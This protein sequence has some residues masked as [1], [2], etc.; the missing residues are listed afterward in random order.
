MTNGKRHDLWVSLLL[1]GGLAAG[2][3]TQPPDPPRAGADTRSGDGAA[4]VAAIRTADRLVL[5]EG[6][7]HQ[8]FESKLLEAERR[9]KQTVILHDFPFYAEPLDLRG[10]DAALLKELLSDA[11]SFSVWGGEKFC[12]GFHP[13]YL[14]ECRVGK[15][16]Y[17]VLVCFGC[18][19]AKVFGPRGVGVRYDLQAEAHKQLDELLRKYH[20]N[21]PARS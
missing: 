14:V 2:C 13:D 6:L 15:D 11:D 20:K 19:E 4:A 7:P 18:H 10:E 5:Y 8:T 16:V 9:Q 21:R 12:G 1:A 3:R 17:R